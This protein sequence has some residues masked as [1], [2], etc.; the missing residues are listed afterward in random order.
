[1]LLLQIA[2]N[3]VKAIGSSKWSNHQLTAFLAFFELRFGGVSVAD[4]LLIVVLGL[5]LAFFD[6]LLVLVDLFDQF[7]PGL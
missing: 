3:A 5:E 6:G 2:T 7:A 4:T 1:M